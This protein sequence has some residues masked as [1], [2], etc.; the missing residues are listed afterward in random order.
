MKTKTAAALCLIAIGSASV[1]SGV[2]LE[3]PT[4]FEEPQDAENV[5][6][7][8]EGGSEDTQPL[9]SPQ[10]SNEEENE[11]EQPTP[12]QEQRVDPTPLTPVDNRVRWTLARVRGFFSRSSLR[13]KAELAEK[14]SRFAFTPHAQKLLKCI[15]LA[16]QEE[17]QQR[18][19]RFCS[20]FGS[21]GNQLRAT[22]LSMSEE[23]QAFIQAAAESC[24]EPKTGDCFLRRLRLPLTHPMINRK[25]EGQLEPQV[26]PMPLPSITHSDLHFNNRWKILRQAEKTFNF[27]FVTS[28]AIVKEAMQEIR[29]LDRKAVTIWDEKKNDRLFWKAW[30]LFV[31]AMQV[32][33]HVEPMLVRL[34]LQTLSFDKCT[35]RKV[36]PLDFDE[37]FNEK[38]LRSNTVGVFFSEALG[39][40]ECIGWRTHNN[41]ETL[42]LYANMSKT[43]TRHFL[44][45]NETSPITEDTRLYEGRGLEYAF[46]EE[47]DAAQEII[48]AE[49][50]STVTF[51]LEGAD[52]ASTRVV[53][54]IA[55]SRVGRALI[56]AVVSSILRVAD[57]LRRERGIEGE[58]PDPTQNKLLQ[59]KILVEATAT[60]ESIVFGF[61]SYF[62]SGKKPLAQVYKDVINKVLTRELK[63]EIKR[64]MPRRSLGQRFRRFFRFG[65]GQSS[66]QVE[67]TSALMPVNA[68]V[69]MVENASSSTP[70]RM[71]ASFVQEDKEKTF[72]RRHVYALV[73]ATFVFLGL[74]VLGSVATG[75]LGIGLIVAGIVAMLVPF[76]G[77]LVDLVTGVIRKSKSNRPKLLALPAPPSREGEFEEDQSPQKVQK[78][79][80]AGPEDEGEGKHYDIDEVD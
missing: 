40:R 75:A 55:K 77:K 1:C 62:M 38:H 36:Q 12:Q 25:V 66:L 42:K 71:E 22:C 60:I 28:S 50:Q 4:P 21:P 57:G 69:A 72:K 23:A 67:N 49:L 64:R 68:H 39:L 73:G 17:V 37:K 19:E 44:T 6:G 65:R 5:E 52:K 31:K 2:K 30:L 53:N 35:N 61:T 43:L 8:G 16:P 18:A 7:E 56:A 46:D 58:G 79:D 63:Q 20:Q 34:L 51:N 9:L 41:C 47:R 29:K 14:L 74:A 33:P 48:E 78:Y 26:D 13:H 3:D 54:F 70:R 32:R 11:E 24:P 27:D 10:A 45:L 80:E 59:S 76:V 15:E